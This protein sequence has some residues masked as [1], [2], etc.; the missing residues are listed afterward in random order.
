MKKIFLALALTAVAAARK[1]TYVDGTTRNAIH[2]DGSTY[3]D[4]QGGVTPR[5]KVCST[6]D[7]TL[8]L[9]AP[10]YYVVSFAQMLNKT[11]STPTYAANGQIQDDTF[12]NVRNVTYAP[13]G[14]HRLDEYQFTTQLHCC[15]SL[16]MMNTAAQAVVDN[17][18]D[19]TVANIPYPNSLVN[20]HH[21]PANSTATSGPC[22]GVV[23]ETWLVR[24]DRNATASGAGYDGGPIVQ[25]ATL[26][27]T[28]GNTGCNAGEF[29]IP[30]YFV[31]FRCNNRT[32]MGECR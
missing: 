26:A 30:F 9:S 21:C 1:D 17:G 10:R 32:D 15:A 22:A 6:G 8:S 5:I 11:S 31:I 4:G 13:T 3:I 12:L 24:P 28:K 27:T 20:V 23:H 7:A 16:V 29:T 18:P 19:S 25:V 2:S 14:L